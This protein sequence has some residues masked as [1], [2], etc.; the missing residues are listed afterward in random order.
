MTPGDVTGLVNTT[1][2]LRDFGMMIT[3]RRAARIVVQRIV[4]M[5][6]HLDV[7][8]EADMYKDIVCQW[9]IGSSP[10]LKATVT[11]L[12]RFLPGD[13][14]KPFIEWLVLGGETRP[15]VVALLVEVLVDVLWPTAPFEFPRNRW[16]GAD[17][18]FRDIGTPLLICDLQRQVF[19]EMRVLLG[20]PLPPRGGH[21]RA[22]IFAIADEA[23]GVGVA[24][25][26]VG[27]GG[28]PDHG[29]AAGQP[30]AV[31]DP[32]DDAQVLA[33]K[34]RNH[35]D[36]T[37]IW[38]DSHPALRVA[39]MR[40][41]MDPML[42]HMTALIK[43]ASDHFKVDQ[44]WKGMRAVPAQHGAP[45]PPREY[46]VVIAATCRL[47]DVALNEIRTLHDECRM[48]NCFDA[49]HKTLDVNNMLFKI[50]SRQGARFAELR[51]LH[52]NSC[53]FIP[54]L[55]L[56]DPEKGKESLRN[57]CVHLPDAWTASLVDDFGIDNLDGPLPLSE[58]TLLAALALLAVTDLRAPYVQDLF[59]IDASPAGGGIT[60]IRQGLSKGVADEL[61][62]RR[63][64]QGGFY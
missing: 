8:P 39:G 16:T 7:S 6:D 45:V 51:D 33:R 2:S 11:L 42:H 55:V 12:R 18:T 13:W 57:H 54:C 50:L 35:R 49:V 46:P 44:S 5:C 21:E 37:D 19:R 20:E 9:L 62:R 41:C 10:K 27:G 47:E 26:G 3:F 1:L 34:N 25:G 48:L 56:D 61:W 52:S 59:A 15:E 36:V 40:M 28:P 38:L 60:V 64:R 22:A 58:L 29:G 43:N 23:D 32:A 17:R 30:A 4:V 31:V 24:G 53:P 14:R 63:E